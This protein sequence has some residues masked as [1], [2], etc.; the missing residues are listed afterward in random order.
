MAVFAILLD[1]KASSDGNP[2][3]RGERL[4]AQG[5]IARENQD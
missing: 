5:Q 1:I 3:L 2:F 4:A